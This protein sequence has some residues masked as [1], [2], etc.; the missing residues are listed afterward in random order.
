MKNRPNDGPGTNI[1]LLGTD[2]RAGLSK[3]ERRRFSTGSRGCN[4]SDTMMLVH[5]S[6]K[7]DR[8]SVV[9]LPRDSRAVIPA[10]RDEASGQSRPA[11]PSKINAAYAEGG[12]GLAAHTVEQMTKVRIDHYLELDFRRFIDGVDE[13]GGVRVC[14]PRR[15]KDFATR[16]DL[17]PGTHTLSGGRSLQYVRSRHVDNSADF[18]RI[19]RQQRYLVGVLSKLSADRTFADPVRTAKVAR[20]MLGS[21]R[22]DQ[23]FTVDQL[24]AL[25]ATLRRLK[26]SATEFTTVPIRG[27]GPPQDGLGATLEWDGPKAAKLFGALA[28]DRAVTGRTSKAVPADPPRLGHQAAFRGDKVTC[29]RRS[30]H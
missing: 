26:P 29:D 10:H 12:P 11:H 2:S 3:S 4:C 27:F 20:A 19:Q 16:L 7:D 14:T 28:E 30:T 13:A 6:A 8:V 5:L 18:G 9:G 1:L 15:L 23:D 25:A 17:K 24:V 21:A 22:V